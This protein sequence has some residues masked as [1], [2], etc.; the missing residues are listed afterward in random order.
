MKD[1]VRCA[2]CSSAALKPP[3]GFVG[4]SALYCTERA[5]KVDIDDGCTFGA[6]GEPRVAADG[7]NIQLGDDA[8]KYGWMGRL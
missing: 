5:G 3:F 8:A 4:Q 7:C 2:H 1:V 6:S